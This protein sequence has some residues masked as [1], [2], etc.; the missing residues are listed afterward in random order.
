M[1]PPTP[2]RKK[3]K[4]KERSGKEQNKYRTKEG[5]GERES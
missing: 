4:Q 1:A 3:R 2:P 5:R